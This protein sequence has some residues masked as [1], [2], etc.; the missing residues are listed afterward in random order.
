MMRKRTE[1]KNV[2]ER[3][4][5]EI[6]KVLRRQTTDKCKK[7]G[8]WNLLVWSWQGS[9]TKHRS[10]ETQ[11]GETAANG[12]EECNRVR[13][14]MTLNLCWKQMISHLTLHWVLRYPGS[15]LALWQCHNFSCFTIRALQPSSLDTHTN[16][17]TLLPSY[18]APQYPHNWSP[19]DVIRQSAGYWAGAWIGFGGW[20]QITISK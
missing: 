9:K 5:K 19:H 4:G 17:Y 7:K 2:W 3:K 13:A 10:K 15:C 20:L 11:V 8:V 12:I 18:C 16:L 14:T 6:N 1:W